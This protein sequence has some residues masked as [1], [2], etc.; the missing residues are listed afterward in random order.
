LKNRREGSVQGTRGGERGVGIVVK[1][2]GGTGV[3]KKKKREK[4]Y[5]G[6]CRLLENSTN[7]MLLR[8]KGGG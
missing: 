2:K 8:R 6:N 4:E 3:G 7:H 5:N 1:K